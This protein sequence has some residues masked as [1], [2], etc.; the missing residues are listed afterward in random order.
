[1]RARVDATGQLLLAGPNRSHR[2][3]GEEPHDWV[4]TG[5]VARIEDGR[6]VLAGRSK[7][8]ILRGA[9]NIYPGLY[10]PA[11][12][13]PGVNLAVLVGVPA[14][15]G[16]EKLVAVI[17]PEPGAHPAQLHRALA[18]CW[19][20]WAARPDHVL[21]RTGARPAGRSRKPDRAAAAAL[22][23]VHIGRRAVDMTPA[24]TTDHATRRSSRGRRRD[25][26]VYLRS[27]PVLFAL[28]AAT[29]GAPVRRLGRTL[30][31]H[32]PDAFRDALTRVP[33]DRDRRR[34]HRGR[35]ATARR[36]WAAVRAER[37]RA[38]AHAPRGSAKISA[39]AGIAR[40]RPVWSA[41]LR[42][43]LAPLAAGDRGHRPTCRRA[44]RRHH[45]RAA[46]D[47]RRPAGTGGGGP[48]GR[49]AAVRDHLP[50]V[51]RP[52][53][54]RRAR[55]PRRASPGSSNPEERRRSRSRRSTRR[56][57]RFPRAVAWCADDGLWAWADDQDE[58]STLVTELLRVTAPSPLLPRVAA[59]PGVVGGRPVRARI[60]C[61]WSPG[62]LSTRIAAIRTA[63]P[64]PRRGSPSSSSA[65]ARTLA[66]APSSPGRELA[67]VLA[68]LCAVSAGGGGGPGGPPRRATRL[69][70]A[71]VRGISV[72][73]MSW[74]MSPDRCERTL[75]R[76]KP[77][78][79]KRPTSRRPIYAACAWR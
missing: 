72:T 60:G 55:P 16:D 76:R 50:G 17:E 33:L 78:R 44:G 36:G 32:G 19:R 10:E 47:R 65:P 21:F 13:V 20:G 6:L 29:R 51:P 52:G 71:D 18:P 38:P 43:R 70:A 3:L 22:A 31:V 5:D 63:P 37:R 42:R 45:R 61:C 62:T 15:D 49:R 75:W 58:R 66:P 24:P 54:A 2:Y 9:E 68:E 34:H 57:R 1:M 79:T 67:D 28:L 39:T 59:G 4:A 46:A 64:P 53:Q 30:L 8:M 23:A 41:V 27:H 40:L 48:R 26:R 14:A 73:S 11:L 12:H 7:D 56:S 25:R 35:R 74:P 69:G 77:W